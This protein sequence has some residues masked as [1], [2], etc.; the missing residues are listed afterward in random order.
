M[1]IIIELCRA[2]CI[3]EGGAIVGRQMIWWRSDGKRYVN[4]T[5]LMPLPN[6]RAV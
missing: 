2:L 1:Q 6:I 4:G 5:A 3:R